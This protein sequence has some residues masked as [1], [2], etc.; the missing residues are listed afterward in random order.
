VATTPLLGRSPRLS[1]RGKSHAL[2]KGC[3]E[4][5]RSPGC[6]VDSELVAAPAEVDLQALVRDELRGPITEL[7]RQV[8][9]ELIREQ[10]NGDLQAAA[11]AAVSGPE[12]AQET[13][14]GRRRTSDTPNRLQTGKRAGS[15]ASRSP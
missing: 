10:L 3:Q 14:N 12:N 5:A 15:A 7:V 9:V 2:G 6:A 13:A 11:E 1:Q 4:T 8:V